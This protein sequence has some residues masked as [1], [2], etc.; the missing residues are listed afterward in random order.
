M[1]QVMD[2]IKAILYLSARSLAKKENHK[3]ENQTVKIKTLRKITNLRHLNM[4]E[5]DYQDMKGNDK[6][7]QFASRRETPKCKTGEFEIPDAV[8]IVPYHLEQNKLVVIEE[9][10]VPLAG[11][12]FGFP[13]GLIDQGE[14]IEEA[15]KRELM[16]ET[17]LELTRVLE[18]SPPVYSTSGMTDES[19]SMLFVECIG[20]ESS[21]YNESSEDIKVHYLSR[22]QAADLIDNHSS[23]FDVK[24]WLVLSSFAASGKIIL[25]HGHS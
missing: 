19:V 2:P 9:F 12:Q 5:L 10:R 13:A 22:Q 8:V 15:G 16:E 4:F 1:L 6:S 21:L 17:G 24:T 3:H 23:L 14:T 20:E 11:Y 7:W 25:N 18:Q